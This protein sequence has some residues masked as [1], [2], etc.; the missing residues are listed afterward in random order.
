MLSRLLMSVA[1]L[2]APLSAPLNAVAAPPAV[3]FDTAP[4][5]GQHQR[6][7][8]SIQSTMRM[9]VEAGP[10]AS[11]AQ[12]A[13]IAQQ[14]QQMSQMGA[15]AMDMSLQQTLQVDRPD[16]Q[17][18]LPLNV[19][20][21]QQRMTMRV[22][23][24]ALPQ[25]PA[26]RPD[27]RVQGRFNPRDF[28]FELQKIEGGPALD[29]ALQAQAG[30]LVNDLFQLQKALNHR[31]I[32]PGETLEL[33]LDLPLPVPVPGASGAMQGQVR[34]TLR[35]VSQGIAVFDTAMQMQIDMDLPG[36][37]A[38]AA[39]AASEP[40]SAP[41]AEAPQRA[42]LQISGG[43]SGVSRLRLTDN[44]MQS[45]EMKLDMQMRMN[46]PGGALMRTDLQM[47]MTSRGETLSRPGKSAQPGIKP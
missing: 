24:Q 5:A 12:H 34:Y 16:A 30:K 2:G 40:A 41:Q 21:D 3:R 29:A 37:P 35:Q 18:W 33:P 42:R 14:A 23:E 47:T 27:L 7:N 9:N 1:L 36:P 20:I 32:R 38:P 45:S 46:Q 10:E 17:G 28:G 4:R 43:G 44:L 31:P 25:P 19:L 15:I 13:R 8:V 26:P 39:S 11:E 22:G 6:L